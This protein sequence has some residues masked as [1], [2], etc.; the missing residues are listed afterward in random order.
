MQMAAH[1]R[2]FGCGAIAVALLAVACGSLAR[3]A[4]ESLAELT[5][6][7]KSRDEKVR[8]QAV[9]ALGSLGAEAKGAVADLAAALAD[10][11]PAVRAHAVQALQLIG[12]SAAT[13][14]PALAKA[15]SDG[16][17]HVRRNAVVA[18]HNLETNSETVVAALSKALGDED[19]SVRIAALNGLTDLGEPAVPKLV[20][21]LKNPAMRYWAILALGELGPQAK[22]AVEPLSKTLDDQQPD[23]RREALIALAK[24]GPD[25]AGTAP[26]VMARLSDPDSAVRNAAA[27]ALGRMGPS[28]AL[29]ADSL[30]KAMAGDDHL[31]R[32]VAA[33][34]LAKVEPSNIEAKKQAVALLTT[35]LDEKNL[36]VQSAA[37]R[38]LADL[39]SPAALVPTLK[40]VIASAEPP[41]AEEALGLLG[42]PSVTALPALIAAVKRP[43]T[44][45]RAA[46]MLAELGP[47]AE[48]AVPELATALADRDSEVRREVLFALAAIGPEASEAQNAI[49]A[50]LHDPDARVATVAAY[51]LG[52]IGPPAKQAE[53]S[54]RQTLESSDPILRVASAWALVHIAPG[55]E[56]L[57]QLA[58]PVLMQGLDNPNIAVRRGAAEGLGV[59]GKRARQAERQLQAA[60]R[61]SDPTVRKAAITALERMGAVID[62]PVPRAQQLPR[63]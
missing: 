58:L 29:S 8:V 60:A 44:R 50:A 47:K 23:V 54:L 61:D 16:D 51:A 48:A 27:L 11:S 13:A 39:E 62:A 19:M 5:A 3:A 37:L 24:I 18:L 46:L 17:P 31:L 52:R 15:L 34:A 25:A 45:G 36:P 40:H 59:L 41:L 33:W 56:R 26:A 35:A 2:L 9:D 30:R 6:K 22:A 1:R 7:L 12:P 63:R 57:G 32:T 20:D 38:G 53:A 21:E 55:D 28:A 4:D 43:E 10:Q 49:L 14:V 42:E